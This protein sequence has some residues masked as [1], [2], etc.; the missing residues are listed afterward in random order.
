MKADTQ[1]KAAGP[2]LFKIL[3]LASIPF[4]HP[5]IGCV[6]VFYRPTR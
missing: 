2:A 1:N 6:L 3:V 5:C 4:R